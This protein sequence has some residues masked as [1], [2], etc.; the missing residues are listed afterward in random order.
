MSDNSSLVL[1]VYDRSATFVTHETNLAGM[2]TATRSRYDA[3]SLITSIREQVTRYGKVNQGLASLTA[4]VASINEY[5]SRFTNEAA[6]RT[7][8]VN[9]L[10]NISNQVNPTKPSLNQI[11][12]LLH[13]VTERITLNPGTQQKLATFLERVI[14]AYQMQQGNFIFSSPGFNVDEAS[15]IFTLYGRMLGGATTRLQTNEIIL[16]YLRVIS[17][18]GYGICRQLGLNEEIIVTEETFGSL[19]V[20]RYTPANQFTA[21]CVNNATD[22]C[23]FS[24]QDAVDIDFGTTL[25]NKYIS[26]PCKSGPSCSGVC[27]T[28]VQLLRNIFW[29]GNEYLWHSKSSSL[30]LYAINPSDGVIESVEGLSEPVELQF[31]FTTSNSTS[32]CVY[33][34]VREQR[35]ST[36]GCST[37]MVSFPAI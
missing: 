11:L 17:K 31:S 34:N 37:N 16:S 18:L 24:Q 27:L 14:E 23:P 3:Q 21:S 12:F 35:W 26:W 33:W 13:H 8:A 19:K 5:G 9:F 30:L 15:A 4:V 2:L 32:R 29:S 6:F 20:S 36:T 7:A 1:R 25:F 22:K 10:L 28:S